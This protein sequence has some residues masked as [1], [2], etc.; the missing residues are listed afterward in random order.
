MLIPVLP[1][2]SDVLESNRLHEPL[3]CPPQI[4]KQSLHVESPLKLE[5]TRRMSLN[6]IVWYLHCTHFLVELQQGGDRNSFISSALVRLHM[7][8][9]PI[10]HHRIICICVALKCNL[11]FFVFFINK[12]RLL[13]VIIDRFALNKAQW[14]LEM[15]SW[16]SMTGQKT[17]KDRSKIWRVASFGT[18]PYLCVSK[19]R[20]L[21][22][23]Q[24]NSFVQYTYFGKGCSAYN[25]NLKPYL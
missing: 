14:F 2:L 17:N 10:K 21:T 6:K 8:F 18:S 15:C 20:W 4:H 3:C 24:Q 1:P 9:N 12:R 23:N 16:L 13:L 22:V 25:E 5:E 7:H 19:T 11:Y